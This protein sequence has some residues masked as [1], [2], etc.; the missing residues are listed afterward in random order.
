[1][2][3]QAPPAV[4]ASTMPP[5]PPPVVPPTV[6]E[7]AGEPVPRSRIRRQ[8]GIRFGIQSKLLIMLLATSILSALVVG[9]VGYTSGKNALQDSAFNRLT[10]V[11]EART[12]E[13]TSFFDQL[14]NSLVIY[15]RGTTAIDAVKAF[16]AGFDALQNATITP[17]QNAALKNYY[18]NVFVKGLTDNT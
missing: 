2:S 17:E 10:Q 4:A 11:R 6:T 7:S 14:T 5:E 12:Q 18:S 15:T 3:T 1:M 16:T 13:I 9:L 8:R